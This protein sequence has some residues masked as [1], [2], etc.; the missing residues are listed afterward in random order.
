MAHIPDGV[1]SVP[2][3]AT[4]ALVSAGLLAVALRRLD[5]QRLPQAAVL[6]AAF[7]VASLISV[8]VGPSTVHLLLN[9]L[10]GLVLGWTVVPALLVALLLQMVFFGYGGVI[11][12]GV[13]LM[14]LALPALCCALLLR[15]LLTRAGLP[16]R[17]RALLIGALTGML[18]V[19]LTG[20]LVALSL[21]AS[22]RAFVPAAQAV[23]LTYVPL[24]LVEAAITAVVVAFLLRVEPGLL[25]WDGVRHG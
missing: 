10:M 12:L 16:N 11:V 7:F 21:A 17:R 3:L 19:L 9:G 15:P 14:N 1:L 6:A 25:T 5:D 24:A 22:G 4:G 8:P 2:V 18:G 23:A 13:N 20:A